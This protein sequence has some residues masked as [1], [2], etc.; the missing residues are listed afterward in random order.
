M[1]II[2]D[3]IVLMC[4]MMCSGEDDMLYFIVCIATKTAQEKVAKEVG[5]K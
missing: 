1:E 5:K 4:V 3:M 2:H